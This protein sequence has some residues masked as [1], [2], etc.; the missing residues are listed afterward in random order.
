MSRTMKIVFISLGIA[1]V[2]L[3]ATRDADALILSHASE[4]AAFK[5][6]VPNGIGG[7]PET[8]NTLSDN[9]GSQLVNDTGSSQQV[10]C[11][12]DRT[13]NGAAAATVALDVYKNATNGISIKGCF[14]FVGGFGGTCT[15]SDANTNTGVQRITIPDS[16][17]NSMHYNY[18]YVTMGPRVGLSFNTFFGYLHNI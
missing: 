13:L 5:V 10:I 2:G 3:F 11:P 8:G 7:F 1:A 9:D 12:V 18:I 15:P 4:C 16:A 6:K 14:T 17:W